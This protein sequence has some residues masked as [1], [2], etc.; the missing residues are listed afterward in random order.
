M[1]GSNKVKVDTCTRKFDNSRL[2]CS[3]CKDASSDLKVADSKFVHGHG[4]VKHGEK[5]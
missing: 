4:L 1:C 3:S 2:E 5:L